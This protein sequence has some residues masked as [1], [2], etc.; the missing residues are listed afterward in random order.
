MEMMLI[1]NKDKSFQIHM[2]RKENEKVY[3][4]LNNI[5]KSDGFKS[6]KG[7]FHAILS[8][9]SSKS[10]KINTNTRMYDLSHHHYI[11]QQFLVLGVTFF[12]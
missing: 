1:Y 11:K 5:I 8:E 9:E 12:L 6:I 4:E 3:D 10:V 7:Y 2:K